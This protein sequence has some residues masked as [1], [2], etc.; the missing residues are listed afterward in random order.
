MA[1]DNFEKQPY[2]EFRI[3]ADF[4]NNF[5]SG[6]ELTL[7]SCSV[8]ATDPDGLD[9]AATITDQTTIAVI[10]GG[11]TAVANAGLQVLIRAGV[12]GITYKITF[13]GVTTLDHKW[14]KD[15]NMKVKEK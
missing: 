9:V 7:G 4:G 10:A 6:E 14:E 1:L 2:E 3:D 8:E 13:K 15:V 11:E 5:Q 12:D